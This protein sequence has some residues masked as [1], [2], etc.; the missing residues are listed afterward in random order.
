[1]KSLNSALLAAVLAFIS[2]TGAKAQ[3][4]TSGNLAIMRVGDGSQSLTNS[5][6]TVFIDQYSTNG[7]L[8]NSIP[9]PDSGPVA[10][11]LSGTASSEGGM[12]RSLDRSTLALIGYNT[13]RNAVTGSLANQAATAVPR[14]IATVDALGNFAML[15]A[16][17]T[18]YSLN[19]ARCAASD[20]TN[21]FWTAGGNAG[22]LY[23]NPPQPPG[24]IQNA[25][26]NTRYTKI[27]GGRLYFSTFSGAG[28]IY[29]FQGDGLPKS[30][31]VTNLLFSTGS[32][33]NPT[34]FDINPSLTIAYVADQRP[35]AGGIQK[36]TN[37]GTA[38]IQAYNFSTGAG[39]FGLVADFSGPAPVIYATTSEASSNRLVQIV[40][41]NS[42]ATVNLLASAGSERLFR[43]LDFTPERASV[44]SPVSININSAATNIVLSWSASA[45]G[46]VLQGNSR[47]DN[48]NSWSIVTEPVVITN[49]LNTVTV[50]RTNPAQF[51]R[52][53]H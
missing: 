9:I 39:A 19:N 5:G 36:W 4:F 2:A 7:T 16:S 50:P 22:T 26:A 33:S 14:A 28:G 15:Q 35:N 32:G 40:D 8:I 17:P 41:T 1:M 21:N 6:N 10:L 23:F 46:Y 51:Y 38:W 44:S 53:K 3:L 12:T 47:T 52:L 20:G 11:I 27:I 25:V 24:T 49:G 34:A 31:A 43:G 42:T 29:T 45:T 18:A 30:S 37:N 48:S 13:N